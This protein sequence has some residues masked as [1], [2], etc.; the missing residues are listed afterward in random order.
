M[1]CQK[2]SF[3]MKKDVPIHEGLSISETGMGTKKTL[4]KRIPGSEKLVPRS[5]GAPWM[6][7]PA[8]IREHRV[9][10]SELNTETDAGG[11]LDDLTADG[12]SSL[13]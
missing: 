1:V 13:Q 10:V 11:F 7:Q 3:D 2:T 8:F 9:G 5:G 6:E 12:L 4:A